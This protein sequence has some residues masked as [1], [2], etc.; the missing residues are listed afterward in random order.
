MNNVETISID[1]IDANHY[2]LFDVRSPKEF[3]EYHIPGAFN[4]SI[5]SNEERA[6][7]GTL[8]KQE[9]KEAA[10]ERGL[11]V[12]A[13]K[14][15]SLYNQ[16]NSQS[17]ENPEK[18]VVIY[19]ARGGFRSRSIAQTMSMMGIKTLQ[20]DGG[21]RSYRK[22]I[23][24]FFRE[25]E[26]EP[27]K[28]IV[29]EGHT[30]TM[31]TKLLKQLQEEG[32]P[33]LNLEEMAGHKGSIFGKIGEHP[34]SQ[35]KFES[36]LY[37]Q[38]QKSEKSTAIIIESE[39]KRIGRVV[40]PNFLLEGKYSGVRI[41]VELP[42]HLRVKYICNVYEPLLHKDE[43]IEAVNKLSK[44]IPTA[45]MLDIQENLK[46][47]NYENVVSLLLENYYDPKYDYAQQQYESE[48]IK[49]NSDSYQG[50]YTKVKNVLDQYLR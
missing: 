9:S 32:Y 50:V 43:I 12:V 22:K 38:L 17:K 10:M 46:T 36:R 3:E 45:I 48:C 28:I 24:A 25:M 31:K 8:Y 2:L 13:P 34:S 14:L 44:R 35:K 47:L 21:I 4:V 30:G 37:E 5:F 26:A 23:D 19:C 7:I 40:V 29:L 39:S 6:E 41:H 1:E 27:R 16:I 49:L 11:Q 42:F 18:Q 15:P 20:L 33:V